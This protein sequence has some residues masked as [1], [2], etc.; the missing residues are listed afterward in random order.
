[1][2]FLEFLLFSK[3][4]RI[5][6]GPLEKLD[7]DE[8]LAEVVCEAGPSYPAAMKLFR[9]YNSE[10]IASEVFGVVGSPGPSL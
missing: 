8:G 7:N 1:M 10:E 9:K 4:A 3:G 2:F 6:E 5:V